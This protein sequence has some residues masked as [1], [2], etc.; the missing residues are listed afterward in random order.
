MTLIQWLSG[1][2]RYSGSSGDDPIAFAAIKRVPSA[3]AVMMRKNRIEFISCLACHRAP[4]LPNDFATTGTRRTCVFLTIM[5]NA[6]IV[7]LKADRAETLAGRGLRPVWLQPETYVQLW[8]W[9]RQNRNSGG[10]DN[11]RFQKDSLS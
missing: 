5:Q 7:A 6:G 1:L 3:A 8:V 10:D 4:A 11:D 2:P 9:L